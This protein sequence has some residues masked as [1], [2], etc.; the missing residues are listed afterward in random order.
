M[1]ALQEPEPLLGQQEPGRIAI[2]VEI[3]VIGPVSN[4]ILCPQQTRRQ[5]KDEGQAPHGTNCVT[6][7]QPRGRTPHSEAAR[8][9]YLPEKKHETLGRERA[10]ILRELMKYL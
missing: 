5:Q 1:F 3:L 6:P 4:G 7:T 8:M 10:S 2:D 9:L